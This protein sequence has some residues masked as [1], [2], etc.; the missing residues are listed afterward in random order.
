MRDVLDS[1]MSHWRDGRPVALASVVAT[2]AKVLEV[3]ARA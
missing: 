3:V 1:L 2:Y